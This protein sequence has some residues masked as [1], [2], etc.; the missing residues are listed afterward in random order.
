MSDNP[1]FN[2]ENY[3]L[4]DLLE[5][6]GVEAIETKES[7]KAAIDSVIKK[8]E[9]LQQMAAAAFFKQVGDKLTENFDTIQSLADNASIN[10]DV[11]VPGQNLFEN[12]YYDKGDASTYLAEQFPNRRDNT[13]IVEDT[14]HMTQGQERLLIPDTH[15]VDVAQG[16]MNPSLKNTYINLINIDSHYREIETNDVDCCGNLVDASNQ[17]LGTSTNFTFDL[18]EPLNNVMSIA[19]GTIEIPLAW[20]PFSAQYGTNSFDVSG[21]KIVIEEGFYDKPADLVAVIQAKIDDNLIL[22]GTMT[23]DICS[24]TLKTTFD[25][26]GN[27]A[28]NFTP[29]PSDCNIDNTGPKID[30]N[31]GWLL[32]FRQPRYPMNGLAPISSTYTSEGLV[33]TFGT[34]Y[35][36]LKVNDFQSNRVTSGIATLTNNQDKFKLPSYYRKVMASMPICLT[37]PDDPSGAILPRES[38]AGFHTIKRA[39]RVGTQNP[40]LIIDGSNNLTQAQKYT[41]QQIIISRRNIKQDRYFAPTNTDILLRFPLDIQ[42]TENRNM[43][44][45]YINGGAQKRSYFGPV[46]LKRLHVSLL[47]DKGIPLDLNH[48]DFSFSLIVEQLYQY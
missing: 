8:F 41:A 37:P 18:N 29:D 24:N 2:I 45:I 48:M 5:L 36:L 17:Y 12:E 4:E 6:I 22:A 47:N 16:N 21:Q 43:P 7:I 3:T 13:S 9:E 44:C 11:P 1:D 25:G 33:N 31:L 14:T 32:G 30:Y 10:R 19:V 23:I 20:Y 27:F 42:V 35:L 39:C 40:N 34:R 46:T 38:R 15:N 28:L 26:S